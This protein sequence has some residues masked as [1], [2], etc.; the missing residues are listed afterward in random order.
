MFLL[1]MMHSHRQCKNFSATYCKYPSFPRLF[2]YSSS[3]YSQ[4]FCNLYHICFSY[5]CEPQ[6]CIWNFCLSLLELSE[7]R[8]VLDCLIQAGHLRLSSLNIDSL[9]IGFCVSRNQEK[10]LHTARMLMT[11]NNFLVHF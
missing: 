5:A 2:S 4:S 7:L 11:M 8:Q 1:S 3:C 6:L 9:N 10:S